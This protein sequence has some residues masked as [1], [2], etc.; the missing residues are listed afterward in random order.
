MTLLNP[1]MPGARAQRGGRTLTVVVHVREPRHQGLAEKVFE[2]VLRG[3][4]T[5][6]LGRRLNRPTRTILRPPA[7]IP[8]Q[9]WDKTKA[10]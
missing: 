3:K 4:A 2:L 1:L 9:Q 5:D 6:R 8:A 7:Q 10:I